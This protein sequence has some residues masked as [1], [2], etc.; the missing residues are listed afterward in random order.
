[1]NI[2]PNISIKD[3]VLANMTN[4]HLKRSTHQKSVFSLLLGEYDKS[5][6]YT[7]LNTADNFIYFNESQSESN[8]EKYS[9]KLEE[10]KLFLNNYFEKNPTQFI[11]GGFITGFDLED[12][13]IL[14]TQIDVIQKEFR[15]NFQNDLL[16][17][18]NFDHLDVNCEYSLK[19]YT[20][21]LDNYFN[22]LVL[23]EC[24]YKIIKTLNN[25]NLSIKLLSN[26][27]SNSNTN[28]E[29]TDSNDYNNE[30]VE[31]LIKVRISELIAFLSSKETI[32]FNEYNEVLH[33]IADLERKINSDKRNSKVNS[34]ILKSLS[35]SLM[36]QVRLTD[37]IN[38]RFI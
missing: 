9:Q 1:M 35:N 17:Y 8:K 37:E 19:V 3:S 7:I 5:G 36:S 26:F 28:L 23:N 2:I 29:C 16:F 6:N 4:F 21:Y 13:N 34:E 20:W 27:I 10:S 31:S 15:I 18:L 32:S 25:S 14:K 12:I 38:R 22:D 24:N 30:N 11:L 33:I